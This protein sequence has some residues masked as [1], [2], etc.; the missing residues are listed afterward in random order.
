MRT[1]PLGF[2]K[3][4]Y[5]T[6]LGVLFAILALVCSTKAADYLG[7]NEEADNCD[8]VCGFPGGEVYRDACFCLVPASEVVP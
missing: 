1:E 5:A 2:A 4:I 6:Y 3:T 7:Y 8:R